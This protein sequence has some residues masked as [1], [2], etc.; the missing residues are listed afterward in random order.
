MVSE[1]EQ[2]CFGARGGSAGAQA[3]GACGHGSEALVQLVD[4]Y[5][6]V[7]PF[8]ETRLYVVRVLNFLKH[9]GGLLKQASK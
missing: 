3:S 6:G 7:P 8:Q 1:S 2:R 5:R 9:F 4:R